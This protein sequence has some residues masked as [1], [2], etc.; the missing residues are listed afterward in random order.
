[1]SVLLFKVTCFQSSERISIK[2]E[3]PWRPPSLGRLGLLLY[4]LSDCYNYRFG[5]Y[6]TALLLV[7]P[8]CREPPAG[9]VPVLVT[10]ERFLLPG[11]GNSALCTNRGGKALLPV[12]SVAV[13]HRRVPLRINLSEAA[14][15]L[16][17][18]PRCWSRGRGRQLGR[19]ECPAVIA[20]R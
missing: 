2:A 15:P 9:T 11:S 14:C 18:S 10:L 8:S 7:S 13:G 5:G 20:N 1:M 19:M 3:R 16:P 6:L 4:S 12:S 17:R